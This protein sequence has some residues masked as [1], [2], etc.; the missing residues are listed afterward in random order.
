LGG[1]LL[2]LQLEHLPLD[3]FLRPGRPLPLGLFALVTLLLFA[4]FPKLLKALQGP[5][6]PP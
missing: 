6:G 4:L 3:L 5:C 2:P 1:L